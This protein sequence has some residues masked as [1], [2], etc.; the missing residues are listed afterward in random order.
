MNRSSPMLINV[1]TLLI[2]SALIVGSSCGQT[3]E[4]IETDF[5]LH[6]STTFT[7]AWP[8]PCGSTASLTA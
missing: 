6:G 5:M 8:L 2:A 1:I 7:A 3:S 4:H